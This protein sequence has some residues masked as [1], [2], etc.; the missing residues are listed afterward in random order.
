MSNK[1]NKYGSIPEIINN[2]AALNSNNDEEEYY[3]IENTQY[4]TETNSDR[5]KRCMNALA[6]IM[7]FVLIMGSL[8]FALSRDF[9]HLYPG[10]GGG[11]TSH[12]V[13]TVHR[14]PVV[15]AQEEETDTTATATSTTS[16]T[17]TMNDKNQDTVKNK[18][19]TDSAKD[20][21]SECSY[22]MECYKLN[23]TGS[24][25]PTLEGVMLDCCSS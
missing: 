2:S 6:P 18:V 4:I 24:C 25:C 13:E 12:A 7:I 11:P 5:R 19:K 3:P 16:K 9:N 20:D 1:K 14:A 10:H 15:A 23:L 8:T 22:H 17:S 21:Q